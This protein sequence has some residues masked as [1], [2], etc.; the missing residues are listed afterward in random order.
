MIVDLRSATPADCGGKAGALGQLVRAGIR[1][2]A[3]IVVP[4]G[5]DVHESEVAGFLNGA[6][7]G[8]GA[9]NGNDAFVNGA[10]NGGSALN[11]GAVAVAVA[12]RSSASDEDL[13]DASAAGQHDSFLGV[14]GAAAVVEK[15]RACRESL[16]STRAVAYR[17]DRG[18]R[19]DPAMAVLIQH[20]VDAEVAGVLFT[21]DGVRIEAS[22]G[23]GESVVQGTVTP[24]AWTVSA[25]G[26][27]ARRVGDKR[28][29]ID[30]G[31]DGTVRTE[32]ADRDRSRPCLTDEQVRR[33][34]AAG[35]AVEAVL[36]MPVDVEWAL[37]GG[38]VWVLQAR[39]ITVAV[40]T[41]AGPIGELAAAPTGEP[42]AA[43][44]GE[45]ATAPAGEPA[46]APTGKP[47]AAPTG[48]PATAP[49]G[50]PATARTAGGATLTGTPGSPGI[51]TGPARVLR[52]PAD[53]ARVTAG[54]II[55]CRSTDPAW[56]PLFAIAAGFVTETGGVLSHAAIVAREHGIPAVL[57]VSGAMTTLR[58]EPTVTVHGDTGT[59]HYGR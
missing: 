8:G 10:L 53:F 24:D 1:V 54:D 51:A 27:V 58:H 34:A 26:I 47:P 15:V 3:G 20:H 23:L 12:V 29:R 44:T 46:T 48:G 35:R 52:G 31:P 37:G 19:H 7:N 59:V 13:P 50:E 16:W 28:T 36:G 38:D 17:R 32:V 56:T 11:G 33:V 40:P 6:L 21:G 42:A 49:T 14:R 30:R 22:W 5:A 41:G 25:G 57:G 45:P 4:F 43:P 18:H 55:V 2:P 39:P 9:L